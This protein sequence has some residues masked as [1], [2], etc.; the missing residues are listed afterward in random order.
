[1]DTA[2]AT[3]AGDWSAYWAE[4]HAHSCPTTFAE[5]Y[6][7]N[8][9]AFWSASLRHISADECWLELACGGGGL[10]EFV[11]QQVPDERMP[12]VVGV[13]LASVEATVTR[14]LATVSAQAQ[15]RIRVFERTSATSVPLPD[16]SV[17]R[18]A[19]QFGF[20]YVEEEPL[21]AECQRLLAPNSAVALIMHKT[22]SRLY[23][24]AVAERAIAAAA[25][26]PEGLLASSRAAIPVAA[27]ARA[28]AL[29]GPALANAARVRE[30]YNAAVRV[31]L[32]MGEAVGAL[33]YAEELLSECGAMVSGQRALTVP[34]MLGRLSGLEAATRAQVERLKALERAAMDANKLG[35]V[36]AWL[37]AIGFRSIEVTTLFE[38]GHEMGWALRSTRIK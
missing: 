15:A 8:T 25:L 6:G 12:K 5:Y 17:T 23:E 21:R 24:Q 16:G 4:G 1:M 27:A 11:A 22:G 10:L 31:L 7:P 13:D 20:E 26:D 32:A 19:S 33:D 3:H 29:D 30:R 14:R 35:R 9:R 34:N 38:A 28:K 18:L 37:G 2:D 36:Q